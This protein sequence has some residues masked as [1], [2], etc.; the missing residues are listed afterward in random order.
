MSLSKKN[1]TVLIII[2]V[3][4]VVLIV[5]WIQFNSAVV[6]DPVAAR[7]KGPQTAKINIVEFIDF[8]CPACAYGAG[9]LK[10]YIE[11]HPGDIRLEVKYYPLMNIHHHALQVASYVECSA[12]QGKFWP[13]FDPLMAQQAQWSPLVNAEGIF[14]Q[15]AKGAGMDMGKLKTCLSLEDVSKTIM[16]EKNMG[17]S[18]SVQSTP[19]YFINK[20]MVVGGKSLVDELEAYFVKSK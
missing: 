5:K 9:K 3:V 18:L 6:I 4:A 11:A 15:L 1:L 13:F 2:S 17:R 8:E 10:E 20:K 16:S 19:T 12:R 14:D 7:T